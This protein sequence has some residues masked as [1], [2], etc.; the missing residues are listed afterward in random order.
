MF[1]KREI[2]ESDRLRKKKRVI[3]GKSIKEKFTTLLKAILVKLERLDAF[4]KYFDKSLKDGFIRIREDHQDLTQTT[5]NEETLD[6]LMICEEDLDQLLDDMTHGIQPATYDSRLKNILN[7]LKDF[8]NVHYERHLVFYE[9]TS[10]KFNDQLAS[11]SRDINYKIS[12]MGHQMSDLSKEINTFESE[13]IKMVQE[14]DT[15]SQSSHRYTE[16]TNRIQDY[17]ETIEMNENTIKMMRK[18][19]SS[20]KLLS[21]LFQ[22]L[23]LLDE[24][25]AYLKE[26]GYVRKLVKKL[27]R[28][29][30]S[31]DVLDNTADLLEAIQNIKK[32]I[33]DVEAIVK[34]AKR[35]LFEDI[36]G[37]ADESIIDRYRSMVK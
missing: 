1:V 12:K 24:Y 33:T 26:D 36:D 2:K 31:L 5:S 29:P 20:F 3:Q 13:N 25:Y 27:Y 4:D 37:D 22:Q 34:P 28:K 15:I 16:M 11:I 32:E 19:Q 10:S 18:S 23:A 6:D 8:Q 9:E 7:F 35:M 30:E 17:H 21:N 14:L